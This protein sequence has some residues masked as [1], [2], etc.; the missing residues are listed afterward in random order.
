MGPRAH[1]TLPFAAVHYLLLSRADR[2]EPLAAFYANLTNA[3]SPSAAAYPA[4]RAFVDRERGRLAPLLTERVTQTN[5]VGRCT[6]LLPAYVFVASRCRK[7]LWIIDVGASAGLNLQFDRYAYD[8]GDG[9]RAGDPSSAVRLRT[10]LRGNPVSTSPLPDIAGRAG[11][12][13]APIDLDDAA[14]T[15]WLEACVWPE[16]VERLRNLRA[17]LD[18]A[19]VVRPRVVKGNAVELL[20]SLVAEADRNATIVIVNTNVL[21]Y[22]SA[23]ERARFGRLLTEFAASREVFWIANEHHSIVANIGFTAPIE[24]AQRLRC[25]AIGDE[26]SQCALNATTLCSEASVRTGAGS[27]GTPER[28]K[29]GRISAGFSRTRRNACR[30]LR[31]YSSSA[32]GRRELATPRNRHNGSHPCVHFVDEQTVR[33][34]APANFRVVA[35]EHLDDMIVIAHAVIEQTPDDLA[36]Q[37]VER[38]VG[39]GRRRARKD[40]RLCRAEPRF[41]IALGEDDFRVGERI[42]ERCVERRGRPI[43]AGVVAV[44]DLVPIRI[45]VRGIDPPLRRQRILED[46]GHVITRTET[47]LLQREFQR[48]RAGATEP[49]AND[50]KWHRQVLSV[51]SAAASSACE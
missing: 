8:Y 26:P 25:A 36:E 33:R 32:S 6:Y 47:E 40:R 50:P 30:T 3:P 10:E 1:P 31:S 42:G 14:A 35:L 28:E 22:F 21:L 23:D 41:R 45:A 43:D 48:Q 24:R 39:I 11:V 44:E 20:P 18:L 51:L 19:R 9:T 46:F 37:L 17:A 16:H 5:E 29:R 49:C 13:L 15:R 7:P 38:C 27:T 34:D 4:F 2:D 12:D